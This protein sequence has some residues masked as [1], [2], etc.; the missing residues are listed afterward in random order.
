MEE[1]D[2]AFLTGLA[3]PRADQDA[4]AAS[5]ELLAKIETTDRLA[6]THAFAAEPAR[7]K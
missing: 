5:R 3:I 1:L 2:R 4:E 7:G 6:P